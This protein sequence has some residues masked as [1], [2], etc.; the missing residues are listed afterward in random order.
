MAR[1]HPA[2]QQV[3]CEDLQ[4]E[5]RFVGVEAVGGHLSD[6]E[7]ALELREDRLDAS[8]VVVASGQFVGVVDG[9]VGDVDVNVSAARTPSSIQL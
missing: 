1:L 5:R 4:Q 2:A 8:A 9:V 3:E 7:A 6:A